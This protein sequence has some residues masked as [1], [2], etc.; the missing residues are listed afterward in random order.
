MIITRL[1][2]GL[3]NQMF[4]YALGRALSLKHKVPLGLDLSFLLDRTHRDKFVFRD[5]G[6]DVFNIDAEIILE[7]KLPFLF[8]N[9]KGKFGVYVD[10]LRRKF[11]KPKGVEKSFAFDPLILNSGKNIF[12][13]GYWQSPKYFENFEDIIRKD[14]ILKSLPPENIKTLAEEIANRN[15]VCVH[16]RRGDFVG[17]KYHEVVGLKYY[18]RAIDHLSNKSKIDKIYVFSDD[19]EWCKINLKFEYDTRFVEDEYRGTK[20]EGHMFLMSCCKNFIIPNSSFAWWGAWLSDF[21]DKIVICPKQWFRDSSID[22][23]DLIPNNWIKIQ[24]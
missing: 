7:S 12:L 13:D 24:P 11:L 14:F 8:R 20:D 2:G 9:I 21:K 18:K 19:V 17:N 4:Q 1:K 10:Y 16:V 22:T 5:Y 23:S 3:G 15:S 6:L